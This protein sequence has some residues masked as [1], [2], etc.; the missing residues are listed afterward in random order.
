MTGVNKV[1][2]IGNLGAKPELKYTPSGV[3]FC[4]FNIAT[5]ERWGTDDKGERK[6]HTEWH[7]ITAW[8]RLAEICG[9]Y[10]DK[11]SKVFIEGRLRTRQWT[12]NDNVKRY[13]TEVYADEM[14]MLTPKGVR[15]Q[16]P[17][18]PE[19]AADYPS[20]PE[21]AGEKASSDTELP[22]TLNL[23]EDVDFF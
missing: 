9:Q 11:G 6:E 17:E 23:D 16:A 8:R 21:A 14:V 13:T 2:L 3:P 10:L 4:K 5:T 1:I 18:Y 7:R 22:E 19:D 20:K 15:E 12:D